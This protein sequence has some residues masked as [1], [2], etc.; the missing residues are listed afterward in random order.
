MPERIGMVGLGLMGQAM[1]HNLIEAGFA[2]QGFDIDP[3]RL[4]D[5]RAQGGTPVDSP[6]AAARDVS[7]VLLSLPNSDIVRHVVSGADGILE[8]A[9]PGLYIVD[10]TTSRP[11]DSAAM[12]A[13]LASQGVR[14]LDAAVSG[15]STMA[16]DK[17]L[18]V[19]AGG[20]AEDFEACQELLAGF[21]RAAYFMGPSGS[22][23][24]TKLIINL[25]LAG[26]RFALMEGLLL[27]TKAGVEGERLLEV[28]ADGAAGSKAMDQKGAK[29]LAGDYAPQGALAVSYKD[30]ALMLEQGRQYGSP[31]L[32]TSLY[33][34]LLNV[35]SD[36]L[37]PALD[38]SVVYEILRE[39]AGLPRRA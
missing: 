4:E 39:L 23:A 36:R 1:I 5:L 21:S 13:E 2:V 33:S 28:L 11:A 31:L 3:A 35:A 7:L 30:N 8:T 19:I 32:L 6:A 27:G 37:D 29:L 9:A 34:Q 38:S 20:T 24:L 17:D 14:F 16:Q 22:G 26:N 10:T 15:T 25:V 12:S 18:I